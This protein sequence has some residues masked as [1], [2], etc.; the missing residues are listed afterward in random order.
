[1]ATAADEIGASDAGDVLWLRP[2]LLKLPPQLPPFVTFELVNAATGT[3]IAHYS[4]TSKLLT[5]GALFAIRLPAPR[6][7]QDSYYVVL[8]VPEGEGRAVSMGFPVFHD[9]RTQ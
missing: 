2:E 8:A 1:M 5:E 6:G 3:P 4:V 7:P 9:A